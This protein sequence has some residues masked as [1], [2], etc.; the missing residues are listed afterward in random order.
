M[1]WWN[2]WQLVKQ[3]VTFNLWPIFGEWSL[4]PPFLDGGFIYLFLSPP[5][6]GE[7]I[8]FDYTVDI[9]ELGWFNHQLDKPPPTNDPSI[10]HMHLSEC[11][12]C[13]PVC[14]LGVIIPYSPIALDLCAA[15]V[16]IVLLRTLCLGNVRFGAFFFARDGECS[17][18]GGFV[19]PWMC[20]LEFVCPDSSVVEFLLNQMDGWNY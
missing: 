16:I 20:E 15:K 17:L 11:Y 7:R 18:Y 8:Q 19:G 5:I 10:S 1:G 12:Q 4:L 2:K 3:L 14:H 13:I 9:F 6:L